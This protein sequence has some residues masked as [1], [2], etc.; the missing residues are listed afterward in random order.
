MRSNRNALKQHV[1]YKCLVYDGASRRF[2]ALK[3]WM[4]VNKRVLRALNLL[5]D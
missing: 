4:R 2:T 5:G 3:Y 1:S